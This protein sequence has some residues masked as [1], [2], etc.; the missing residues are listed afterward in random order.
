MFN[1]R[2]FAIMSPVMYLVMNSI[3][4]VIYYIGANLID[5]AALAS[6]IDIFSN[7][8]VFTSYAMQVIIAF[9]ILL[10]LSG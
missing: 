3:T 10:K 4:L 6:K 8:I 2:T 5:A 9:L 1:Q 7:M